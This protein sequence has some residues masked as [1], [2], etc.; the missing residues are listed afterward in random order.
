[1]ENTFLFPFP[2]VGIAPD[3]DRTSIT[4]DLSAVAPHPGMQVRPCLPR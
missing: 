3:A 4:L 1:M 2:R